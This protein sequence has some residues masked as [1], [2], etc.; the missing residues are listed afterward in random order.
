VPIEGALAAALREDG[1]LTALAAEC[2]V[3]IATPTTLMIALK[4]ISSLWQVERR[5]RN[6]EAIAER[7]GRMYEKF[8][9]FVGDLQ[10]IGSNLESA[11]KSYDEGMNKLVSGRG[12][13]VTQLEQ[14]KSMGAKTTKALPTNLIEDAVE[15]ADLVE[16]AA[17][18]RGPNAA[19]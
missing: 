16:L 2:N 9:G 1:S 5:N 18:K 3:P 10:K 17:S 13:I 8:V 11:R 6:A 14:L 4:T 12:N 19:E 15:G 7:A